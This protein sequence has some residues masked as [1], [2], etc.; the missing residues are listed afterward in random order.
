MSLPETARWEYMN[1]LEY[2]KDGNGVEGSEETRILE[3][4]RNPKEWV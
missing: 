1:E 2:G 3:A 4:L